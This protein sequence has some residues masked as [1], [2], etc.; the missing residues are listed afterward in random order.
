MQVFFSLPSEFCQTIG[1][2]WF[3]H[4]AKLLESWQNPVFAK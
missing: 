2:D 3:F 1:D 4:L